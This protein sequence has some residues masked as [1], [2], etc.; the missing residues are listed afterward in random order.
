M[1][2]VIEYKIKVRNEENTGWESMVITENKEHAL[3]MKKEYE[4]EENIQTIVEV[5]KVTLEVNLTNPRYTSSK[6][7]DSEILEIIR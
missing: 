5:S 7:I 6:I 1:K 2:T 3:Q 4:E